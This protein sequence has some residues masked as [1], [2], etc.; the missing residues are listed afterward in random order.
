MP[1]LSVE[2]QKKEPSCVKQSQG[3]RAL[4]QNSF[5]ESDVWLNISKRTTSVFRWGSRILSKQPSFE[6]V[7]ER[8]NQRFFF[9]F[10]LHFETKRILFT[11]L[12]VA[13]L[14]A[15]LKHITQRR[16]RKQP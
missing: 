1:H 5:R 2:Q 6:E 11:D 4:F 3:H 12:S 16:K 15:E 10:D 14:P 8:K 13:G 9:F 7:R